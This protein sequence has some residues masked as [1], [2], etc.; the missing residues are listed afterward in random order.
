[1]LIHLKRRGGAAI[2]LAGSRG[3]GKSE[4]LREFCGDP[5]TAKS[6][7]LGGIIGVII[8]A[9]VAYQAEP[10]LRLLIRRLAE[11]VPGYDKRA[12]GRVRVPPS[13]VLIAIITLLAATCITA[14]LLLVYGL[15]SVSRQVV[16]WSLAALG[17]VTLLWPLIKSKPYLESLFSDRR[18]R[19]RL[20]IKAREDLAGYAAEIARNIRYVET[21]TVSSEGSASWQYIGFKRTSGVSLDQVPLTEL[22]LVFELSEFVKKIH[23][24]GYETRVGIDELDKLVRGN[25]AERF[26]TGIK[27]LFPIRHCSFILTISE[28]ASSQFARRGMPI[29]DVFDSSLDAVVTLQPLTFREAKRLLHARLPSDHPEKISDTQAIMCYCLAGGLPRDFLRFCRQLGEFKTKAGGNPTFDKVLSALLYSEFRTRLDGVMSALRSRDE[30]SDASA[31]A[32]ELEIVDD[33][34]RNNR[35]LKAL[36][37]FVSDDLDFHALSQPTGSDG[38][39]DNRDGKDANWIRDTKRQLYSYLYFMQSLREAF[40]TAWRF[41]EDNRSDVD[42]ILAVFEFLAGARRQVEAD[43]A[44]GWRQTTRARDKL[45]LELVD[46]SHGRQVNS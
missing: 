10:F 31:L 14:G 19:E 26:L 34:Y 44:A 43:A 32:A 3:A 11:A 18:R 17:S 22:D 2:G 1:V 8:P 46:V 24:R 41:V 42:K 37:D 21:R 4:L 38:S 39:R 45:G 25:D 16:G 9:P 6:S 33:A 36:A 40:G 12:T 28:N 27:A 20:T 23:D 5:A 7:E 35:M 30:G 15:P 29:R 13:T